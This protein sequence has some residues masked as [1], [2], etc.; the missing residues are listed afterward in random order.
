[1]EAGTMQI[2]AVGHNLFIANICP[3]QID[4]ISLN[5]LY[6]TII[7]YRCMNSY[8]TKVL[9]V[10]VNHLRGF[11]F[12]THFYPPISSSTTRISEKDDITL[13]H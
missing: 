10:E 5:D 13:T 4:A 8:D 2:D 1:M 7:S 6:H 11:D 12:L 9:D 3:N